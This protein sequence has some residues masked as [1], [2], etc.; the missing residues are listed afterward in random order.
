MIEKLVSDENDLRAE[1]NEED[2][3]LPSFINLSD[4]KDLQF[5]SNIKNKIESFGDNQFTK[6]L[7]Y[8]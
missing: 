8:N 6:Y 1:Y 5:E 2:K 3:N 4:K 7:I